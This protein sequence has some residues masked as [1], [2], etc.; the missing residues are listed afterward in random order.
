MIFDLD[1]IKL[2]LEQAEPNEEGVHLVYLGTVMS[3]VPSGKYYM[4]W[5][6]GNLDPCPACGGSG[7]VRNPLAKAKKV[8]QAFKVWQRTRDRSGRG[9]QPSEHEFRKAR[10]AYRRIR[11]YCPMKTF[12]QC[13][14]IGSQ[15]AAQDEA[16]WEEAKKELESIG[17]FLTEGEGDPC[18]VFVGMQGDA[19]AQVEAGQEI[20]HD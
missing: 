19:E 1:A 10:A 7:E 20:T 16:W 14:G 18:D 5:A 11:R 9:E 13:R 6:C 8:R 15:E 4:P 12:R 3:L 17:A 2:E